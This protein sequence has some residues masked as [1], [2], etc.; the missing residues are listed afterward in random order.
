MKK[1]FCLM[2]ALSLAFAGCAN[3]NFGDDVQ[4]GLNLG[5]EAP[6]SSS[7]E[8]EEQ[9][10]P[11]EETIDINS[12]GLLYYEILAKDPF[13]GIEAGSPS[14]EE[15]YK[16]RP[17][18]CIYD[19]E[20]R[21]YGITEYPESEEKVAFDRLVK[22]VMK[23][24]DSSVDL[25]SLG[26]SVRT[27]KN[28]AIVDFGNSEALAQFISDGP[29]CE[30]LLNSVAMTVAHNIGYTVGFTMDGGKQFASF[31]T[32]DADGYGY[33]IPPELY[34]DISEEEF[35]ALRSLCEYSESWSDSLPKHYS[36]SNSLSIAY[37]ESVTLRPEGLDV[38][39]AYAGKTGEFD[40]PANI[41][42]EVKIKAALRA[43]D[44]VGVFYGDSPYA[45]YTE[46]I[47]ASVQDDFIPKEWVENVVSRL[48]G[49]EAA[50]EHTSEN[51][52]AYNEK[53]GVYTP[54]HRGGWADYY[55]YIFSVTETSDGYE[56]ETGYIYIGIGG[57]GVDP[58]AWEADFDYNYQ[59]LEDDPKAMDFIENR[60]PRYK[61][62]IKKAA[63][64][65]LYI[66]SSKKIHGDISAENKSIMAEYIAPIHYLAVNET[67]ASPDEI[68]A[69][70]LY[71][72]YLEMAEHVYFG[73][74]DMTDYYGISAQSRVFEAYEE[75]DKD[76]VESTLAAHFDTDFE[77]LR[78]DYL[79]KENDCYNYPGYIGFGDDFFPFVTWTKKTD[80]E[81]VI[82]YDVFNS[83]GSLVS[84]KELRIDIS[85]S[86]NWKYKSCYIVT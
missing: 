76:R 46:A 9:Q 81:L 10:T 31:V 70:G 56:A 82:L 83:A 75:L 57:Y 78:A 79:D 48:F 28:M 5:G 21:M 80:G 71:F 8:S 49:P 68:S 67:W 60:L 19:A 41:K 73:K 51:G 11:P 24:L 6:I 26:V 30:E 62:Q 33:Y 85:D 84:S 15:W 22:L 27:E 23:H 14:E 50:V 38:L 2:I 32:L 17:L 54:P 42:N 64:G 13:S 35:D 86:E 43:L 66:T 65:S 63:D 20:K 59:H 1:I 40:S 58:G 53:V 47:A 55:T 34:G 18:V 74:A 37:D 29:A 36:F 3:S 16:G 12:T 4:D 61:V 77:R 72:T 39:L 44:C 52:Y 69:K 45:P 25:E 7:A